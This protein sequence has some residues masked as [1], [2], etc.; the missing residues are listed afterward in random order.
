[1]NLSFEIKDQ[2]GFI[3]F[4]QPD[5][6]V[7]VLTG[8]ILSE[9][10]RMI[11]VTLAEQDI[12][13]LVIQSAKS[14]IFIAGADINEIKGISDPFEAEQKSR[15]GQKVLD[16]LEDL[17]VPTI[18]VIDGAALGG[19]CE[20]ALACTYRLATFNSK[21]KIGLPEVNLGILPGFGG[22][23]RLP[24]LIGLS[25][26]LN[27]ILAGKIVSG[28][29]ALRSGLVDKLVPQ[30]N[31]SDSVMAFAKEVAGSTVRRIVKRRISWVQKVLDHTPLGQLL[32][33]L[34]A[35]QNIFQKTKGFYPAPLK[36]LDVL[37]KTVKSDRETTM[38]SE[39]AAFGQLAPTL[40]CKNLIHVFF[41]N[42]RFKKWLPQDVRG[43]EPQKIQKCGVL[44]AGVMG[45]G[46]A[47]VLS[48]NDIRVRM[49]DI[50]YQAV[51][52]GMQS[53]SNVFQK[54]VQR[55]K[56]SQAQAK[57]KMSQITGT[58]DYSGFDSVECVIEAVVEN[59]DIKKKVF[60]EVDSHIPDHAVLCTNTSALSVTE[61][62][63]AVADPSRVIGFHFFNPVH[64][65]PLVEIIPTAQTSPQTLATAFALAHR[66]GKVP[67]Q[68]KDAPGFLVNRILLAYINEAGHCVD[69]GVDAG[70][71]DEAMTEFG[72]P[73]G[74]LTLSD[75]V[76]LDVG[77]KV[78]HIL[79]QGFGE[80]FKPAAIFEE[81]TAQKLLGKKSGKGFYL[82]P[83][84]KLNPDLM[85]KSNSSETMSKT[86]VRDR[87]L[88]IMF[89]E[90]AR[91]LEDGIVADAATVDVGMIMGTG[92]PPFRGGLLRYADERKAG[93]IVE[94]LEYLTGHTKS[95]RY[96]P[97]SLLKTMVSQASAFY[98]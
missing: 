16:R 69:E 5:S 62:A 77:T 15:A 81:V 6:K 41:L 27:M 25:Q 14:G 86:I 64:R 2:I 80:R 13:A 73:M 89:N 4:D 72:M 31:L 32:V 75:E 96:K 65:M 20:L 17:K 26:A 43:I 10:E 71:I 97:C 67:I 59:M 38:E 39:A 35:R 12:K 78:L 87:L 61:M 28:K 55:R 90:A 46:I 44:G 21:V 76:G 48:A 23:Y 93:T 56:L 51:A 85:R 49:K 1:M 82:Y 50:N 53:A 83:Q 37:H 58:I 33:F 88:Y 95:D 36:A 94:T 63:G 91:C 11:E 98:E 34:K 52:M 60:S 30:L 74:P 84:K 40:I 18:A 57:I 3:T 79:H 19:G 8:E 68:V 54:G 29:S 24:R 9:F 22:T 7:N 66:L 42:E 47:R 92:F 45:G 70:L